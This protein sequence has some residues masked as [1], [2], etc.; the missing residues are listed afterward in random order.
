CAQP[1][2][3]RGHRGAAGAERA[4]LRRRAE[5]AA[6][7]AA[8]RLPAQCAELGRLV[9]PA[10][11]DDIVIKSDNQ[12]RMTRLRDIGHAELGAQDY[13]ANGY[14]DTR[15]AVPMLIFQQPGSNA[16]A[17]DQ[18]VRQT[19]QELAQQFPDGVRYD[20]VY[21]TTQFISQSIQEVVKTIVEAI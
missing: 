12:G 19:M 14:L 9:E 17:T 10:Q 13:S 3:G 21:D 6:G 4:G 8:R 2:R 18:R 20:I 11:F 15:E 16:L 1:H 7:D 5:P